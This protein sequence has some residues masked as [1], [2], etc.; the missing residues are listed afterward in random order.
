MFWR[1]RLGARLPPCE[2]IDLTPYDDQ[3]L[4]QAL[5]L[6]DLSLGEIDDRVLPLLRRPR[7]LDMVARLHGE[8][9]DAAE[10]TIERLIYEDQRDK[11][12]RRQSDVAGLMS[13]ED[14]QEFLCGL[15]ERLRHGQPVRRPDLM[16]EL[17]GFGDGRD[18]LTELETGGILKRAGTAGWTVNRRW[19]VLGLGLLLAETARQAAQTGTDGA[20]QEAIRRSMEPQP[21]MDIKVEICGFAL[22]HALHHAD[23]RFAMPVRLA[24]FR[25]WIEGRNIAEADWRRLPAYLPLSP[26]TYLEMAEVLW[27]MPTNNAEAQDAFMAGFLRYARRRSVHEALVTRFE[28]WFGFVHPDGHA[29]RD[30]SS[31][32]ARL[33]EGRRQVREALGGETAEGSRELFG[34]RLTVT[35]DAGLLRLAQVALAVISHLDRIPFLRGIVTGILADQVMGQPSQPELLYWTL[36]TAPDDI[37]AP[38]LSAARELIA[39]GGETAHKTADMLLAAMATPTAAAAREE[40]AEPYRYRHPLRELWEADPCRLNMQWDA[41][42]SIRCLDRTDVPLG[43]KLRLSQSVALDPQTV[44][45]PSF[46]EALQQAEFDFDLCQVATYVD[47]QTSDDIGLRDIEPALCAAAPRRMAELE[48]SLARDLIDRRHDARRLLAFRLFQHQMVMG[49]DERQII[50]DSWRSML[51]EADGS[52]RGQLC[53]KAYLF[54]CALSGADAED[55]V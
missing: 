25:A 8:M 3:E 7:Y 21:D 1:E 50:L 4:H 19:L 46:V 34:Y 2:E 13:H 38:L 29:G 27:A 35:P 45:P 30:G 32:E 53:E 33:E 49:P 40:V 28:R 51:L 55:T 52:R 44:F 22:L 9:A 39:Q 31:D 5:C 26:E 47:D 17:S 48:R 41:E 15:V 10:I 36:R 24:L 54:Q 18:L 37:E 16:N 42:T 12:S 43:A 11:W 6:R 23:D 20:V 14:F